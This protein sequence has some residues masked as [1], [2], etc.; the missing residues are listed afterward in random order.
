MHIEKH[1]HLPDW[2][3]TEILWSGQYKNKR[4]AV[5]AAVIETLPNI[6]SKRGDYVLA[7]ILARILWE[8]QINVT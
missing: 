5:E 4:K 3:K 6:N 7:P 2:D 8:E 1:Q